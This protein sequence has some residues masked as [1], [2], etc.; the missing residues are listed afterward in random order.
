[1]MIDMI[2][3]NMIGLMKFWGLMIDMIDVPNRPIY[4]FTTRTVLLGI[5][6]D[7][8]CLE[9]GWTSQFRMS[10]L[11]GMKV[12]MKRSAGVWGPTKW[13]LDVFLYEKHTIS[14]HIIFYNITRLWHFR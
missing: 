11:M 6:M 8:G 2:D 9:Y 14:I 13:K 5:W 7:M 12:N 10:A 4:I 3:V 1:M